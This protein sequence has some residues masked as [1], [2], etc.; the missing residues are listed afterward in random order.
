MT[1]ALGSV[2]T[3]V[4]LLLSDVIVLGHLG[5]GFILTNTSKEV[6]IPIVSHLGQSS[7]LTLEMTED[8]FSLGLVVVGP[9]L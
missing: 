4:Q 5:Q 6:D 1:Q 7:I 3:D 2:L 8:S 9:K